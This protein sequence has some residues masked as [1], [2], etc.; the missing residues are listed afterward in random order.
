MGIIKGDEYTN[1]VLALS[2]VNVSVHDYDVSE[3]NILVSG[4]IKFVDINIVVIIV[5]AGKNINVNP[6]FLWCYLVI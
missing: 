2:V 1:T 4:V 5:F 6:S 3:V